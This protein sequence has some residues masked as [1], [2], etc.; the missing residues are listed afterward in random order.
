MSL[1]FSDMKGHVLTH[2]QWCSKVFYKVI[3]LS[4]IYKKG[5]R[6][7]KAHIRASILQSS[8]W[9]ISVDSKPRASFS[10]L[11]SFSSSSSFFFIKDR[12]R[13]DLQIQYQ[14]PS[15]FPQGVCSGSFCCQ[16]TIKTTTGQ[17]LTFS[18]GIS[19]YTILHS[20]LDTIAITASKEKALKAQRG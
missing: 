19:P 13:Q 4:K 1:F 16:I 2:Q 5:E 9:Y 6:W 3:P 18:T 17:V 11:H 10:V 14:K 12:H 7:E 15:I 20:L 8:A